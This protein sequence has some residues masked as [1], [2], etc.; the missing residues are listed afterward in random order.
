[1]VFA[2]NAPSSGNTFDAFLANAKNATN[3]ATTG[4]SCSN[5]AVGGAHTAGALVAAVAVLAGALLQL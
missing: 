4:S 2:I 5:G 3:G 1:M